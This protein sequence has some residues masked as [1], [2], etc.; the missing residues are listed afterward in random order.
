MRDACIDDKSL[1]VYLILGLLTKI[2]VIGSALMFMTCLSIGSWPNNSARYELN[3]IR[4]WLVTP[5][6]FVPLLNQWVSLVRSLILIVYKY[7]GIVDGYF[8]SLV[9]YIA[10][11]SLIKASQ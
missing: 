5:I 1:V 7:L 9:A 6:I 4:K 3:P 2:L 10:P 8:S 11:C